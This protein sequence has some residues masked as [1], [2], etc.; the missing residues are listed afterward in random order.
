MKAFKKSLKQML[1]DMDRPLLI[2]TLVLFLFGTL[3]IVTASSSEAVSYNVSLYHYF[4]KQME[5]LILGIF[6]S[7]F[8][9][10]IPTKKWK[11]FALLGFMGVTFLLMM[12]TFQG[13]EHRGAKN[14]IFGV[15]PSEFAK[16]V[17]IVCLSLVFDTFYKKLRTKNINHYNMIGMILFVGLIFPLFVFEQKDFGSMLIL[18]SIF[19]IMFLASPILKIEKFRTCVFLGVVAI[20]GCMVMLYVKGYIFTDA[21]LARFNFFDPCSR[22]ETGRYQICTS[23]IAMNSGGLTGLG[24]GKSKQ[25][26]SYIPEAH[27]DSVF[28]IIVEEYGLLFV[29]PIFIAY[30]FILKRI[31]DISANATTVRGQ[32]MALGVGVYIFMHILINLGG[33]FG[34]MPLTGVPL[35]FLSYG[36]SFGLSL[37]VSLAIVQRIYIETKREKIRIR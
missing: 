20:F 13:E 23:F 2:V 7:L 4:F 31:F 28:S 27:T 25:K 16:P 17:L 12:L 26:Y 24:V 29:T 5:I 32:Y 18:L 33:L 6:V 37:L 15:Q 22:Y 36:G 19:G 30:A 21:Q 10:N 14:W 34:L 8:I 9:L 1:H 11:P 3:N 35:P